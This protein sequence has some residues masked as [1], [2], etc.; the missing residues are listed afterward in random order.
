RA[1]GAGGGRVDAASAVPPRFWATVLP[2][3]RERHPAAYFVGEV[4]HGDYADFVARSTL[5]SVTQYEL[6]KAIWSALNEG[7][8]YELDHALSR[9]N[10]FLDAFVPLT[11]VGNHDVTRRA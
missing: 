4:I 6:W 2:G 8:F 11:F 10:G 9:H 1:R 3:V 7:N 5:G